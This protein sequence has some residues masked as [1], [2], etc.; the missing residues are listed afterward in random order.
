MKLIKPMKMGL[1]HKTYTF[2]FEH[3]TVISPLVF[4]QLADHDS[5]ETEHPHIGEVLTEN[6]QWPL[7]MEALGQDILDMVMPKPNAEVL[8]AGS[9]FN[10]AP[11]TNTFQAAIE[12]GNVRKALNLFGEREWKKALVGYSATQALPVQSVSLSAANSFGGEGFQDNPKGSGYY[13]DRSKSP[14]RLAPI[15]DLHFNVTSIRQKPAPAGFGQLDMTHSQRAK[16]NGDYTKK[17]WLENHCPALAPDTDM[18]LF[19][20]ARDDQQ[21]KGYL[22]G[23]EAYT[24]INLNESFPVISGI[25]PDIRPRAFIT[26]NPL[27]A[28]EQG[29]S[30]LAIEE[31]SLNLDTVWFFPNQRIG[32]L[33][34]R[35]QTKVNDP[36]GLDIS[37]VMLAYEKQADEPRPIAYYQQV[38]EERLDPEIGALVS[39]DESQLSP[40]K[41]EQQ[42]AQEQQEIEDEKAQA[43]E[44]MAEQQAQTIE[45]IKAA[46]NGKLPEGFTAPTLP[47]PK[48]LISKAAIARGDF[49]A[50]ALVDDAKQ[51]KAELEAKQAQLQAQFDQ[52]KS[53]AE[54]KKATADPDILAAAEK[55]EPL[56]VTFPKLKA[57]AADRGIELDEEQ[58]AKLEELQL[59]APKFNMSPLENRPEDAIAQQKRAVFIAAL[60]AGEALNARDW[61][62][63][64][65]SHLDL[66]GQDLSQCN[67]ENCNFEGSL[68][69]Q[70]NLSGT[71]FTG[72]RLIKTQ[73]N[74]ANL[75]EANLS[76]AVG[77]QASFNQS[78]M[79]KTIIAKAFLSNCN[80]S[81][82]HF[83]QATIME[84]VLTGSQ[85]NHCKVV[86]SV[87]V[88]SHLPDCDFN[89][90][91]I[92]MTSVMKCN[93]ALTRWNESQMERCAFLDC[94]LPVS[95]FAQ[96]K[97]NKCQFSGKN[98]LNGSQ[99][100][101]A[102]LEQCG[103]RRI[104][105]N[106]LRAV[107]TLFNQCD[108]GDSEF[109][110]ARFTKA[111]CI[112]AI[113]SDSIF[114]GADFSQA[115]LYTSLLRKTRLLHCNLTKANFL[116]TDSVMTIANYSNYKDA[117]NVAPLAL[118]RW[119]DAERNAA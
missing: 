8:V 34:Y 60:E 116:E 114:L 55:K 25:L 64:D 68:L 27:F 23:N 58:M 12:L 52:E 45:D 14:L 80:F 78:K 28:S 38:L 3:H 86:K 18:R 59:Q 96:A 83:T 112:Q 105:G 65:L 17:D 71:A 111:Q 81:H 77:T 91:Q 94:Q 1:L 110:Y 40:V 22:Q 46:N 115:N 2:R 9:A 98:D 79:E 87:L 82:C 31:L 50:K 32:C 63:C 102:Q 13:E 99:F 104:S 69:N 101:K 48:I 47:E 29:K 85:F 109:K 108:M 72:A 49:N 66:S 11:E 19:Q 73:F 44:I 37:N 42:L 56:S 76:S 26:R 103:L 7:I 20:A 62:G 4:F 92:E 89:H 39:M 119:K 53:K 70:S 10:P 35:G 61:S 100:S 51:Q 15:E 88:G 97:L 6:M 41:T 57:M 54:A 117:L 36:D 43:A 24:L 90:S 75:Q 30:P 106:Y 33:I 16:Y 107:S 5:L 74:A 113:M 67:F 118:R 21:F 84:S 95:S 93:L